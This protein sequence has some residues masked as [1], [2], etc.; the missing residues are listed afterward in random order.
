MEVF[1]I[2][3]HDPILPGCGR[4]STLFRGATLAARWRHEP[5]AGRASTPCGAVS[6]RRITVFVPG[7]LELHACLEGFLI[8]GWDPTL[9]GCGGTLTLARGVTL[10]ASRICEPQTSSDKLMGVGNP[11]VSVHRGSPFSPPG[12]W[13][14]VCL[15]DFLIRECDS[16]LPGHP[17]V[18]EPQPI[19]DRPMGSGF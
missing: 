17:W 7:L 2:R 14:R 4:V 3:V 1:P 18:H 5:D 12:C 9:P 8:R 16:I 10:S 11:A 15:E 13:S 6:I 19:S